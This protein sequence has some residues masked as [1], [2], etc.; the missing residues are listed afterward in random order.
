MLWSL[1]T[2]DLV[3]FPAFD[4]CAGCSGELLILCNLRRGV[5]LRLVALW[6]CRAS[7]RK[8]SVTLDRL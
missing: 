6:A 4:Q 8:V 5:D 2:K 7:S 3:H 1:Y